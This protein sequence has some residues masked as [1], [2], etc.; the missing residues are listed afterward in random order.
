MPDALDSPEP[1]AG[2]SEE[3]RTAEPQSPPAAPSHLALATE[4]DRLEA[5]RSS[6]IDAANISA[7]LWL[8][9]LFV[10][11]Y[12]LVAVG[13][14]T[15]RNLF[16]AN[17][18]KL[19]F[20]SVE[21]PLKGF[22]WLGPALFLVVHAYVLLHF[23]LLSSKVGM[24]DKELRAQIP[25]AEAIAGLRR[26]LPINIFVQFLAGPREVRQGA[27]GFLLRLIAWISLMVGPVAL[28]VFFE[29]QFLPYHDVWITMWQRIA[30]VI[31][32]LLLWLLWPTILHGE[33]AGLGWR[34]IGWGTGSVLV[35][36]SL[37]SVL[38][39]FAIAT[40]PG[41]WLE[42]RLSWFPL[43]R[44]I[45]AGDVDEIVRKPTS[46]WSNR[47]VLPGLDVIDHAKFDSEAKIAAATETASLRGRNLNGA[48]LI[49]ADLRRADFT[50]ASLQNAD[51]NEARLQGATF[52]G[53]QLQAG[54]LAAQLQGASLEKAHLEG[55]YLGFAQLQGA[56]LKDADLQGA[57]LRLAMLQGADLTFAQLQGA[58]LDFAELRGADLAWAEFQGASLKNANLQGAGL[59]GAQLQ[60][61]TLD[62]AQ[63]QGAFLRHVFVWR[64]DV[65]N[66]SA[67]GA[68]I[69]KVETRPKK[70]CSDNAIVGCDWAD[71]LD[72]LKLFFE[73]E[74]PKGAMR[75]E[76]LARLMHNL[77]PMKPL[78]VEDEIEKRWAALQVS[79]PDPD[80]YAQ[81]LAQLWRQIGCAA[82]GAPFVLSNLAKFMSPPPGLP[83]GIVEALRIGEKWPFA[84]DSAHVP[85]L[86]TDFLKEDCAGAR[87]ISERIRT[88]LMKL[89]ARP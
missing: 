52:D 55:A 12:L 59:E 14:V 3:P 70:P 25:Y 65:R 66:A 38:L 43:R 67:E 78:D 30:V 79:S 63:L 83:T 74:V 77:D 54:H 15:H 17:A 22:F 76:N 28:L 64:A 75:D 9:Y 87:G 62:G 19:P 56:S 18:I 23:L 6:V 73:Q 33:A 5:M 61:A 21:L 51:L 37:V 39:V 86:V 47:L 46:L 82:D 8:S 7:G 41:E 32:L 36:I 71:T 10:L 35:C 58:T 24:F 80:L 29:L 40:F 50:G 72:T 20:L 4:A 34:R 60:G 85:Q 26:L 49:G 48:V 45:V 27:I 16:F 1:A 13:G 57:D 88:T 68:R 89:R 81:R 69:N 2:R 11:F 53:A 31:D 84:D 44:M 42:A